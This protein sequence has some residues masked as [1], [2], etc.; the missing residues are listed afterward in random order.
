MIFAIYSIYILYYPI[1]F[2][3]FRYS[4]TSIL[5][6]YFFCVRI[7]CSVFRVVPWNNNLLQLKPILEFIRSVGTDTLKHNQSLLGYPSA[8]PERDF[9]LRSPES[10]ENPCWNNTFRLECHVFR[11]YLGSWFR[12]HDPKHPLHD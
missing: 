12:V 5:R 11:S 1:T 2:I 3:S 7:H 6:F 9:K 8:S 4:L 10:K